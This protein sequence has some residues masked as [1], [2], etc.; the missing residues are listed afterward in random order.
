M[1][2]CD[3]VS[4]VSRLLSLSRGRLSSPLASCRVSRLKGR[5][6]GYVVD[7]RKVLSPLVV[8]RLVLL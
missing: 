5:G 4:R 7:L 6:D 3:S 1:I 2:L 8:S